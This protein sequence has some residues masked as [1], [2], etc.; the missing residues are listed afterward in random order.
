MSWLEQ[1]AMYMGKAQ[2][3]ELGLK[4]LLSDEFDVE[5]DVMQRWTLG[6]IIKELRERGC[7]KDFLAFLDIV[8]NDRNY[9]AHEYLANNAMVFNLLKVNE[10]HLTQKELVNPVIHLEQAIFIF[11]WTNK[12]GEWH[13]GLVK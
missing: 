13:K 6:R 3:L 8:K 7:R 11:D 9:I 10:C 5:F 2:I 1:F 4:N 12:Y